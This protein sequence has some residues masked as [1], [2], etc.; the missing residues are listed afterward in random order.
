MFNIKRII[1]LYIFLLIQLHITN[2]IER[3]IQKN[4]N[5]IYITL[6]ENVC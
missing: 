3:I 2:R 1:K 4:K 5:G 6:E